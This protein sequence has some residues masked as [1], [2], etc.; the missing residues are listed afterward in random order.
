MA[1]HLDLQDRYQADWNKYA[2]EV[3]NVNLDDRQKEILEAVQNNRRVSV[4]SGNARGKDFV[5]AVAS[6]CF[7]YLNRP[8]KVINTAPTNRQVVSIMMS[9]ISTIH[10]KAN[11]SLGGEVLSQKIKIPGKPDWFLEGFKAADK[12]TEAW[13]GFHSQK[14]MVVVT[15]A[16]GIDDFTF[17]AIE[18]ILTGDSRFLIVYNP[19]VLRG[20]SYNSSRSPIYKSF[21][22]NCL[23]A[24]NV[25]AKKTIYPG[26][27]NWEWIDEKIRKPGWVT[28]IDSEEVDPTHHDFQWE[29][30]W[31]RPSNLAKIKILGEYPSEDE[32]ALIPLIWIEMAN[33]RWKE[34]G[35]KKN[36]DS[37]K[38]GVDV[39]G[40]GR[41]KTVF[42]PRY[43]NRVEKIEGFA[44]SGHME[45]A[46]KIKNR[47]EGNGGRAYIDSIGEGAGVY[48]RCKEQR[49]SVTSAKASHSA[50]GKKDVTGQREFDNM[51][52]YMY[53]AVRDALDPQ[54]G[55]NLEL[56]PDDE[57]KQELTETRWGTRSNGKIFIEPKEDIKK[58]LGRSP[59]KSDGVSLT[60]YPYSRPKARRI[61]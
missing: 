3:L 44:K 52:A 12:D 37:L 8:S 21:K 42:V 2:H 18:S 33:E 6:L 31:Y 41:D 13:Q 22:L 55:F 51:R 36:G 16:S 50:E 30:K 46:G 27:V 48:S 11:I 61:G 43:G 17:D 53:W 58:R 38:L 47:V 34:N 32:D 39:A 1:T 45:T 40:M 57:L 20:E 24:P 14:L 7:L 49:L 15:E 23:D 4:R 19:N 60:F 26:Q 35:K 9:E 25:V 59:D 56:P 54:F 29:G 5:A 28:A 10:Q